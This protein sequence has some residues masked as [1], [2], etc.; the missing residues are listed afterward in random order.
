LMYIFNARAA[1][2][3]ITVS[4]ALELFFNNVGKTFARNDKVHNE[5]E[6]SC[7][8]DQSKYNGVESILGSI[9]DIYILYLP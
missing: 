6:G 1:M 5:R 9:I 8:I 2:I 7:T 4:K 3:M